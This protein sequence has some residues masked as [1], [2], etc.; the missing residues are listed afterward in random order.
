MGPH[1]HDDLEPFLGGVVLSL[2][3]RE[4]LQPGPHDLGD[5][6]LLVELDPNQHVLGKTC[7]NRVILTPPFRQHMRE[8]Q[9]EMPRAR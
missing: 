5:C 1:Q 6:A 3:G 9:R 2:P 7:P 8:S 4:A